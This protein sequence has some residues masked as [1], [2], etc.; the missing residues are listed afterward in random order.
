M[1]H[2][3]IGELTEE[4]AS[5]PA[6]LVLQVLDGLVDVVQGL[7]H[8]LLDPRRELNPLLATFLKAESGNSSD[9]Y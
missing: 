1:A 4:I 8:L 7:L 5:L 9:R 2:P 3:P 6:V